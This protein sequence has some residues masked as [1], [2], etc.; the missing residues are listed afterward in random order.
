M[1]HKNKISL[2]E[3]T[4]NKFT[5]TNGC[6]NQVVLDNLCLLSGTREHF[7]LFC[8]GPFIKKFQKCFLKNDVFLNKEVGMEKMGPQAAHLQLYKRPPIICGL[9]F[10]AWGLASLDSSQTNNPW[11]YCHRSCYILF[12]IQ[13]TTGEVENFFQDTGQRRTKRKWSSKSQK[14]QPSNKVIRV[15]DS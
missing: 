1:F 10:M 7:C 13:A 4:E 3:E 9:K 6:Q 14:S 15:H 12:T 8:S 2:G 11:T 5:F